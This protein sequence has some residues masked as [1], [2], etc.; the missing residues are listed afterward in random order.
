MGSQMAANTHTVYGWVG[1]RVGSVV[2]TSCM[3]RMLPPLAGPICR[4]RA[5]M[6][7][8]SGPRGWLCWSWEQGPSPESLTIPRGEAKWSG[9]PLWG[10]MG[11]SIEYRSSHLPPL[12]WVS[13]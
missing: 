1:G 3:D 4:Q 6:S 13:W 10:L 11:K 5:E 9:L 2:R 12:R 7:D 8:V